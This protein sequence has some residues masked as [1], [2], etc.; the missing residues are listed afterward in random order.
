MSA[1]PQ[2]TFV[3]GGIEVPVR[4]IDNFRQ[5]YQEL[6]G[7]AV[8]RKAD[9]SALVQ[10]RWTKLRT[11]LSGDGPLPHGLSNLDLSAALTLKCAAERAVTSSSNVITVPAARRSDSGYEPVGYAIVNKLPV[12]TA[13]SW[14]VNEATLT[15]VAG[16][17]AYQVRY[18]PELSVVIPLGGMQE[19]FDEMAATWSWSIEAEGA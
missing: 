14:N 13:I 1:V 19:Q 4:A 7:R 5:Q 15:T 17:T 8:L 6:G 9:G 11:T 12:V 10:Q 16:A 3:L 18:F 2:P